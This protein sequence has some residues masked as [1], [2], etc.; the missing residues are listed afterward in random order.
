MVLAGYL[1]PTDKTGVIEYVAREESSPTKKRLKVTAK[2]S[3]N[4]AR[5]YALILFVAVVCLRSG[6]LS[7]RG[8]DGA[9]LR[10]HCRDYS[11]QRRV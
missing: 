3:F 10:Y 5:L 1:R 11:L 2:H 8:D 4:G 7:P 6:V 9:G